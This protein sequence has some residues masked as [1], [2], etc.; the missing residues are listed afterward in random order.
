[1]LIAPGPSVI[2]PT[3]ATAGGPTSSAARVA[4]KAHW[5]GTS[6][7]HLSEDPHLEMT[8]AS[9]RMHETDG[10]FK[11]LEH[12]PLFDMELDVSLKVRPASFVH[13]RGIETYPTHS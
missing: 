7:V 1:M 13:A 2:C 4:A 6:M 8:Y 3:V 10:Q 5:S 11:V 9:D 12:S